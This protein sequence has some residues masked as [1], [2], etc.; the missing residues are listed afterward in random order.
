VSSVRLAVRTPEQGKACVAKIREL[1]KEH[2]EKGLTV[3]IEP[4][5]APA[6]NRQTSKLFLMLA[7][8]ARET[9]NDEWD[10]R[11]WFRN[12][13]FP[14]MVIRLKETEI[15]EIKEWKDLNKEEASALIER[16]YQLAAESNI[17]LSEGRE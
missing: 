8:L 12:V 17:T 15:V 5:R 9:G 13:H 2:S 7:E 10:L 1:W 16:V 11:H 14:H 4:Y 3:T 6:S